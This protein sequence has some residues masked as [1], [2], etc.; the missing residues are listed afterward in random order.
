MADAASNLIEEGAARVR[1]GSVR[2]IVVAGRTLRAHE[3]REQPTSPPSSSTMPSS[4]TG[5]PFDV[6]SV[7][8]SGLVMPI[9][10]RYASA[11]N[12]TRLAC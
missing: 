8:C 11:E 12:D 5:L 7:G 4:S 10:L 3:E 6:F 1:V 2:Q 9:S